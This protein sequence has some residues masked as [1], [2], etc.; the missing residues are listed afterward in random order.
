MNVLNAFVLNGT[1]YEVN[2]IWQDGKPLVRASDVGHV[3]G[4]KHIHSSIEDF[5]PSH[6]VLVSTQSLGGQQE[7]SFL[8]EKG[9]TRLLA[10]SRKPA[11]EP[12]QEWLEN[13]VESISK[14]GKYELQLERDNLEKTIAERVENALTQEATKLKRDLKVTEHE[15]RHNSLLE[16]NAGKNVVYFGY[17]GDVSG[18]DPMVRVRIGHT[19]NIAR[20]T[21]THR[22]NFGSYYLFHVFQTNMHVP[23]ESFLH[24]H[25]MIRPFRDKEFTYYDK[26]TDATRHSNEVYKV[27]RRYVERILD[28]AKR[29]Y[30]KFNVDVAE[31]MIDMQNA[32]IDLRRLQIDV[33]N[34]QKSLLQ[35]QLGTPPDPAPPLPTELVY[36]GNVRKP[37]VMRGPKYQ[38]YDPSTK[39]LVH[40]FS[41]LMEPTR[42]NPYVKSCSK[43]MIQA[44]IAKGQ[45][46]KK[47]IW[48]K[49]DR[50]L[51]DD[52]VQELPTIAQ[53]EHAHDGSKS[54]KMMN[55][56]FVAM[57]NIQKTR[58]EVVY[59]DITTASKERLFKS[60]AA[61]SNA[62]RRKGQSS[63]HFW[64]MWDDC[65][66]ALRDN[67]L[68]RATLPAKNAR[69]NSIP[70]DMMHPY[71]D[72]EFLKHFASIEDIIREFGCGR[73]L[74]NDAIKFGC[75]F[76]G[77]KWVLAKENHSNKPIS[78]LM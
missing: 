29:N 68:E 35:L 54:S 2:I 41:C 69:V 1:S 65:A 17:I 60:P 11:A 34:E 25:D 30:P 31:V 20:R 33:L 57:L 10:R 42:E 58:I 7:T 51:P 40:T 44:A 75:L 64:I 43:G 76:R 3:L 9:V 59:P 50:T 27:E 70:V 39:K 14:T 13:V 66:Q 56:G 19:D 21:N 72:N 5:K 74:L 37:N 24:E 26:D 6:K 48:M 47:F 53:D 32:T 73:D 45:A 28:V 36:I 8:T 16:L 71:I 46:Y 22:N 52:H 61:I 49:L 77:Y 55:I 38:I 63:G 78:S 12:F 15:F 62:I 67:Y 18:D 4:I 23:F